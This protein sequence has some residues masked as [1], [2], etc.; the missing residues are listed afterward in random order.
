M[1]KRGRPKGS[2][3]VSK[4]V[5]KEWSHIYHEHGDVGKALVLKRIE[6]LVLE[7]DLVIESLAILYARNRKRIELRPFA[8][9][10]VQKCLNKLQE[11]VKKSASCLKLQAICPQD[12]LTINL[13]SLEIELVKRPVHREKKNDKK[14]TKAN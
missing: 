9:A 3:K 5:L 12:N 2:T 1:G 6:E 13:E 7:K 4:S 8:N 11:A 14:Q 10:E